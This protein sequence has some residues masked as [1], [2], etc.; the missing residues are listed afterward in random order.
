MPPRSNYKQED[1]YLELV[2]KSFDSQDN[3][4]FCPVYTTLAREKNSMAGSLALDSN[5]H[6]VLLKK[7]A[8]AIIVTQS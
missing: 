6:P 2:P 5:L 8:V 7:M 1:L 4:F 3:H